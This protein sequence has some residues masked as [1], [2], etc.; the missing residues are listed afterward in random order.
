MKELIDLGADGYYI[1]ESPQVNLNN[2]FSLKNFEGFEKQVIRCFEN[3]ILKKIFHVLKPLKILLNEESKKRPGNCK[4]QFIQQG[5]VLEIH[6]QIMLSEKLIKDYT[7]ELRWGFLNLILIIEQII[8]DSYVG[9]EHK[10]VVEIDL[11]NT[12]TCAEKVKNNLVL[13]LT[14][15]GKKYTLDKYIVPYE[16]Q[17][18]YSTTADRVP[19]NYR[20]T[21]VLHFKYSLPL[22]SSIFKFHHLYQLRSDSVAH[23]GVKSVLFKDMLLVIELLNILIK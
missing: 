5:R 17:R 9:N 20:L 23:S 4:L 12:I 3:S 6:D 1:K 22:D 15:V 16:E 18:Y 8:K 13:S 14:P 10:Q 2:D 21:C 7:S 11:F 19:F